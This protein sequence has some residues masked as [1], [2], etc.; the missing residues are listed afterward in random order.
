MRIFL[1][2][3]IL[4]LVAPLHPNHVCIQFINGDKVV[5]LSANIEDLQKLELSR[6]KK[7]MRKSPRFYKTIKSNKAPIILDKSLGLKVDPL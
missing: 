4:F 7:E 2:K 6:F 5:N 1:V 3:I